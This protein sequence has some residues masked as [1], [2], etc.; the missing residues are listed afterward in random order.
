MLFLGLLLLA[1]TAAFTG[2]AISDNL[3]GGGHTSTTDQQESG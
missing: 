1:A 2:L 3:D